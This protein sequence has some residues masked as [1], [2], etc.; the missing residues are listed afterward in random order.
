MAEKQ[1][2]I[3]SLFLEKWAIKKAPPRLPEG[4]PGEAEVFIRS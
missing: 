3:V 2:Q 4:N 1:G